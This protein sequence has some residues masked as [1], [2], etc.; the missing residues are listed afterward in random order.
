MDNHRF[1]G[2]VD[3]RRTAEDVLLSQKGQD[4]AR[5][6]QGN[7]LRNFEVVADLLQGAL[8]D[9]VTVCAIY[10][11]KHVLALCTYVSTRSLES[12]GLSGR[13]TDLQ[14]YGYLLEANIEATAPAPPSHPAPFS[15][16]PGLTAEEVEKIKDRISRE[17]TIDATAR[18][19]R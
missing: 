9:A 12:E 14:N 17:Q 13:F 18:G 15:Y 16:L 7:R 10:W 8:I 5:L 2:L 1:D 3:R 19:V 11:L 6:D 4:Y